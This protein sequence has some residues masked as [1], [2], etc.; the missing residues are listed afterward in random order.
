MVQQEDEDQAPNS[1]TSSGTATSAQIDAQVA[2]ACGAN[3][4]SG[5]FTNAS[6]PIG[7][8]HNNAYLTRSLSQPAVTSSGQYRFQGWTGRTTT[9]LQQLG[10]GGEI[11]KDSG[12]NR[13]CLVGMLVLAVGVPL[14]CA[15]RNRGQQSL[16]IGELFLLLFLSTANTSHPRPLGSQSISLPHKISPS[17]YPLTNLEPR[18]GPPTVSKY[19]RLTHR[20]RSRACDSRELRSPDAIRFSQRKRG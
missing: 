12:F 8:S 1:T 13:L 6:W 9:P 11:N 15:C 2:R 4:Q 10:E 14:M 17:P 19:G 7:V 20:Q 18:R 16:F 3:R 5:I